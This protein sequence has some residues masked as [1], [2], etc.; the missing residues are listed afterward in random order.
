MA[1]LEQAL[2]QLTG[3]YQLAMVV[4]LQLAVVGEM[5]NPNLMQLVLTSTMVAVD[6]LSPHRQQQEIRTARA[7]RSGPAVSSLALERSTLPTDTSK[8]G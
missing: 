3:M 4:E 7:T 6:W 2:T 8:P 1:L 5:A